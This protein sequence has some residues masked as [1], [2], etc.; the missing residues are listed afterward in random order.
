MNRFTV[1]H[2]DDDFANMLVG[3]DGFECELGCP[4]DRNWM[5]DGAPVVIRLN[6]YSARIEVL[7]RQRG[8]L[9]QRESRHSFK[10]NAY[11]LVNDPCVCGLSEVLQEIAKEAG[12]V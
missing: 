8:V 4:E 10:C 2:L 7:E 1:V 3:P 12:D 11:P 9:L 5:R 6:E